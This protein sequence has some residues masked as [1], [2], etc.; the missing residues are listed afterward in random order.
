MKRYPPKC[1]AIALIAALALL[2]GAQSKSQAML[3]PSS[4]VKSA[5]QFDRS[6]DIKTI[7]ATLESKILREKLHALGLSDKEVQARLSKMSDAEVHQMASQIRS[8]HPAGDVIVGVL[9][10]VL[11]VI[12]IIFLVKRL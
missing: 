7:Q 9:V 5:P 12:L 8:V 11:L 3:A 2:P 4:T 6:Q 10:I 1:L